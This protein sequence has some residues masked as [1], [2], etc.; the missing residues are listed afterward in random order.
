MN[1]LENLQVSFKDDILSLKSIDEQWTLATLYS[2]QLRNINQDVADW[3]GKLVNESCTNIL[4]LKVTKVF[5]ILGHEKHEK[6]K[7]MF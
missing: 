3:G 7:S 1:E 2:V 5:S 4:F 6:N